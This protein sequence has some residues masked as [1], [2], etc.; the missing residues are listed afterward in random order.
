VGGF[1]V[2][3]EKNIGL[4]LGFKTPIPKEFLSSNILLLFES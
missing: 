1:N 4:F 2:L 3:E